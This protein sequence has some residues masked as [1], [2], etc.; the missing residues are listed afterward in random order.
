[1]EKRT[2]I[3]RK[4][5]NRKVILSL[6]RVSEWRNVLKILDVKLPLALKLP[7]LPKILTPKLSSYSPRGQ[8]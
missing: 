4:S 1:M 3:F 6:L 7:L 8:S 5:V 2:S